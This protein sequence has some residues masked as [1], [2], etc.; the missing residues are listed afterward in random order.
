M[1]TPNYTSVKVDFWYYA[2]SM[3]D[4]EDFWVRYSSNGGT[5]WTTVEDY[6]AATDFANGQFYHETVY[7]NESTY[8]LTTQARIRFQC[9]ASSNIDDVYIDEVNVSA[10]TGEF[11]DV[12]NNTGYTSYNVSGGGTIGNITVVMATVYISGYGSSGSLQRDNALPDMELEFYNGSGWVSA[13]Y[14]KIDGAGNASVSSVDSS[15][16]SSWESEANRQIRIRAVNVD[17]YNSTVYDE[18]NWTGVWVNIYN[19][20]SVVNTGDTNVSGY[21]IMTVE[22]NITGDWEIIETL[23]NDTESESIKSIA[24]R[25][26]LDI[27]SLWNA[28][29]WNTN[30]YPS[31]DYRVRSVLVDP[32][33]NVLET[34]NGEN[35][36]ATDVFSLTV[37]GDIGATPQT[38]GYGQTVTVS[39]EVLDPTADKVYAYIKRPGQAYTAYLMTNATAG[40]YTYSFTNTWLRGTYEYYIWSNNTAHQN[41]T[42]DIY[43]FYVSANVSLAA[44]TENATYGPNEDVN[45]EANETDWW[46][47][48][49]RYR[50]RL[51]VTNMNSS[52]VMEGG[53]S[54]KVL[55]NT[56]QLTA[57]EKLQA[58]GD[59]LRIV[60]YNST[61]SSWVE[62]DRVNETAFN[63]SGTEIWFETIENISAGGSDSNYYIYYGNSEASDPPANR[64]KIYLWWDDFSTNKLS[65]YSQGKWVDIHGNAVQYKAPWYNGTTEKVDFDTG[66]NY[67]SDIYPIGI[68]AKDLLMEVD[69]YISGGYPTNATIA[70]VGRVENPGTTSTHYYFDYSAQSAYP[71]PG[72]T[73]DSWNTGERSNTVYQADPYYFFQWNQIQ[74]I[75]YAMY[76][77]V[78]EI[79][80]NGNINED[81]DV[82]V[83]DSTH[84]SEGQFGLAPAQA[85]GWWDNYKVRRFVGT[86][87]QVSAASETD[88]VYSRATNYGDTNI[89]GYLEMRVQ[90]YS[91]GSWVNFEAPLLNDRLPPTNK[92]NITAGE[93]LMLEELW[94]PLGW[95]TST[96]TPGQYRVY[97]RMTDA[98]GTTLTN[99]DASPMVATYEFTILPSYLEVTQIEHENNATAGLNEYETGDNIA[100]INISVTNR[101]TNTVNASVTLNIQNS[102]YG[103]VAWGPQNETNCCGDMEVDE[104]C[105]TRFDNSSNGYDIPLTAASGGY[106]FYWNVTM[107]SETGSTTYNN[108]VYFIIHKVTDNITSTIKPTKIFQNASSAYNLTLTNPWSD[109]LSD[110]EVRLNTPT[111]ISFNVTCAAT[112]LEYCS[113]ATLGGGETYTFSFSMEANS[114]PADDYYFNATINYTNPGGEAKEWA[115]IQ[116][117]LLMVRI[118]G[119]F[120]VI[121][122]Y[123]AT[124]MR[125]QTGEL[126]GYSNNTLDDPVD[127]MT[128]EWILPAGWTNLTG[129]LE[130]NDTEQQPEEIV[131]NNITALV[132]ISSA[133]GPQDIQL[134]SD[135]E[136][137]FED[138]DTASITVYA[139]T[140][141]DNL[142]SNSTEPV[143]GETILISGRLL[144][145]NL[146]AVSGRAV[147]VYDLTDDLS[148]GSNTTLSNGYFYVY[149]T[150]PQTASLGEHVL[151]VSYS[152]TPAS[153][154]LAASNTTNITVQDK[155]NI[156]DVGAA[157]ETQGYGNNVTITANV[158]DAGEV[159]T[160]RVCVTPPSSSQACYDM[161]NVSSD[162]YEYNYTGTW[163]W[164]NYT[165]YV[166]ANNT[167][168]KSGQS[169]GY[170]FH[171]GADA[172]LALKTAESAYGPNEEVNLT[173]IGDWWNYSWDYRQRVNV[174]ENS[175]TGITDY[176]VSVT[177]NTAALISAGKMQGD[178]KDVRVMEGTA[179]LD[180]SVKS[181]TCNTTST[182]IEFRVNVSASSYNDGV[183]IYYGNSD[184]ENA[185]SVMGYE[186][187]ANTVFIY[188]F[189]QG[190]GTAVTD[191]SGNGNGAT[192]EGGP[193]WVTSPVKF[194]DYAINLPGDNE[195]IRE[196]TSMAVNSGTLELWFMLDSPFNSTSSYS[197]GIFG[198]WQDA[199]N[200]F[201]V[202]LCGQDRTDANC[203]DGG[204]MFKTE[205][206]GRGADYCTSDNV[207]WNSGEWYHV[208]VTWDGSTRNIYINGEL[209]N[210]CSDNGISDFSSSNLYIGAARIDEIADDPTKYFSGR[211]DEVR[212]SNVVRS[213]SDFLARG[214]EPTAQ[215]AGSEENCLSDSLI[216]NDYSTGING[217]LLMKVQ[218]L[219]GGSWVD[220]SSNNPVVNDTS[221][222]SIGPYAYLE[223]DSIWNGL[224]EGDGWNTDKET[225]G[226]YRVY[227]ELRGPAGSVLKNDDGTYINA[228]YN[229]N[230]TPPPSVMQLQS[231]KIYDVTNMTDNRTNTSIPSGSGLNTTFNL[232]TGKTYRVEVS[233]WNN[234]TSESEW[235][236]TAADLIYQEG[237]NS[238]WPV[239]TSEE[240]WYA[241][242]TE[243]FTGGSYASGRVEWNASLGGHVYVGDTA[244]FYYIVHISNESNGDYPA[245]TIINDTAFTLE[246]Y[247]VFHVVETEEVPP[248]IYSYI[249]DVSADSIHRGESFTIY[250]RWDE[251]IGE[252]YA[253]FNS[254]AS[255]LQNHTITLPSPN[256]QNWTNYT[257]TSNASWLLGDHSVKI[258]A[259]DMNGN[260]NNTL[261]YYTV[262]VYGYASVSSS[263]MD[264]NTAILGN[265][266]T[267]S[268]R[269]MSD[270]GSAISGYNVSFYNSTGFLGSNLTNSTGWADFIFTDLSL[271]YENI[272]CNVTDY[273]EIYYDASETAGSYQTLR[274][275][276]L[277]APWYEDVSQNQSIVYRGGTINISAY[278]HDNVM[279][280]YAWLETN[281]TGTLQ[282]N[283]LSSAMHLGATDAQSYFGVTIPANALLGP[284][285]WRIHANDT[286]SNINSTNPFNYTNVWGYAIINESSL[287]PNPIYVDENSVMSCRVVDYHT[288]SAIIGYNITFYSNE[289]GFLGSNLTNS[290]GWASWTYNDT[291]SGWERITCNITTDSEKYY[292]R[293]APY[294]AYYDLRA[295]EE[296]EDT[297][298]PV[299]VSYGITD[300]NV[301]KGESLVVY[302]QWDEEILD[303]NATYN[304][305]STTLLTY[306]ADTIT[307]N[308]TN[309]TL[310]TNSSWLVG[311][312]SVKLK[313]SDDWGNWNNTL[314]YLN[315]NVWGHSKL[316]WYSPTSDAQ[317]SSSTPIR[318]RVYDKDSGVGIAGYGVDFYDSAWEY[319]GTYSTNASGVA[320]YTWDSSAEAVGQ[321]TFNC[322]ITNSGYYNVTSGDDETSGTFNLTGALNVTIDTPA[323]N[324]VFHRGDTATLTSTTR[325]ELG[326]LVTP[327]TAIWYNSTSQIASGEDTSWTIPVSNPLGPQ[328]I[329]INVSKALYSS[330]E[331]NVTLVVWGWS[332]LSMISPSGGNHSSGSTVTV[333][334]SVTD[335]NTSARIANY[336]VYFYYKNSTEGT[337]HTIG[338]SLSDSDGIATYGWNT[339][340]L[341][342]GS[343]EIRCNLTHNSTIYYNKTSM[344]WDNT[345]ITLTTPSGSTEAHLIIPP[346]IPGQ[347]SAEFDTGYLVGR[348]RT[349][350]L[351]ANVTCRNGNCGVVQGTVRYNASGSEPDT[352]VATSSTTPF[353]IV[354]SPA[355]NPKSC[356]S[357]NQDESCTLNWTINSTGAL[358]A[359]RALDVL[360]EAEGAADNDTGNTAIEISIVLI[361]T[362]SNTSLEASV[363]PDETI[364]KNLLSGSPLYIA[365]HENSND[366]EGI[367]LRGTTLTG[368]AGYTM[369]VG[370][371]S[372][373]TANLPDFATKLTSLYQTLVSPAPAATNQSSYYWV[374]T[375]QGVTAGTYTGF[376][377]I[378]ANATG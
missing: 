201:E 358:N 169:S 141:L 161:A 237:L 58:D 133:L 12:D 291:T 325:D 265:P 174:T 259:A 301:W 326:S 182:K 107:A 373:H 90:R 46:D 62:I 374:N 274:T 78:Q 103:E 181:S 93:S 17:Y 27:A 47:D 254:T 127:N 207:Q 332:N 264:N 230:I 376:I 79:W 145:D 258:Y 104:E 351:S 45:L 335:R 146:T 167:A 112:G 13:G 123:P 30:S 38:V 14:M 61:G 236:I 48:L 339:G 163:I 77:N 188:H 22:T 363:L 33:G 267:M 310:A 242:A 54:V 199:S 234:D 315:F 231:I 353:Y 240:V 136:Q 290:T 298:P 327:S 266:S 65:Q 338:T 108:S 340:G 224:G 308:W 238:T 137:G 279:L 218:V 16:I 186:D 273:A 307:G 324:A 192:L 359:V 319:I 213:A 40:N 56:A 226:Q 206:S 348:N 239:G 306:T 303:A 333:N 11:P 70:L 203:N 250:A 350:V 98:S 177:M 347:G 288:G 300:A 312:H 195:Y 241:N 84:T 313:A 184:A 175:G 208:A 190:S 8:N 165:Y 370:N 68:G 354:G 344:Y 262:T 366:A 318:C 142:G 185:E 131:W 135:C 74:N 92:R 89:S 113:L 369:A 287:S 357:L 320:T 277:K 81:A 225:P 88:R 249:Y 219:D 198:I 378:M 209:D 204:I 71:S 285:A 32:S 255:T 99:D 94:N 147:S 42:S 67:Q 143:K 245:R 157:P 138:W 69:Y 216:Y 28:D 253:E 76:G 346:S 5:G 130:V 126:K 361:M 221:S 360:F 304:S 343:Y 116:N 57:Q 212:G 170:Q 160:V 276:E 97:I 129:N 368:P 284:M 119:Q 364:Q 268:C 110:I 151:N 164:G 102:S 53:Y 31:A 270:D 294:S 166:W 105:E 173:P 342:I 205:A 101:N 155:P 311:T 229:F 222:R 117:K 49:Y 1:D 286:S 150:V 6:I 87:P 125:G 73:V 171:I 36:E 132:G 189:T 233:V 371:M 18:I 377:Y 140:N 149:Y 278:W 296:D 64:S 281:E 246:D 52:L 120:D 41:A 252:A 302:A 95:N 289:T 355:Q 299:T 44:R 63:A 134:H 183:Y 39:A 187:D 269:V 220:V 176:V 25:E 257:A 152:G 329:K 372:Y 375:P 29:P 4:G 24:P 100:W 191:Y 362:L 211:V 251:A 178:C 194:G 197:Q 365:L 82:Y 352:A 156:T 20:S 283:S 305:T 26:Y 271:G 154:Y 247:S 196:G 15:V 50:K 235:Q 168:G 2:V 83:T 158:T 193:T 109:N 356:G 331:E 51:T 293:Q 244:V 10:S 121:Y 115:E 139:Q 232:F 106:T 317:R 309:H 345:T 7:I 261:D 282:N 367:Y 118:P 59:D 334:C 23:V 200:H 37:F 3:E 96:N 314:S 295:A 124:I 210:A 159:D 349:F 80:I 55:V 9:D 162:I 153:Y 323:E 144:L 316:A 122:S 256:P 328:D 34:G 215:L 297:R 337:Y 60:W 180:Y 341:P 172:K 223:L 91:G 272:T 217:Y 275:I 202:S 322:I 228:T 148:L 19:G 330:D 72:I 75:K 21:F 292:E 111:G 280:D 214:S 248:R 86:D 263:Q 227:A 179:P 336:P 35:F 43:N 85:I 260:W 128:L 114:T 243:N 321:K 66:D